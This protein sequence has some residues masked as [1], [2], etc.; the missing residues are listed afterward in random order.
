M[1][2]NGLD[3]ADVNEAHLAA[4]GEGGGWYLPQEPQHLM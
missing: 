3:A 2:L 1:S 4:L